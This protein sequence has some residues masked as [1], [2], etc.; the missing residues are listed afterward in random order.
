[1]IRAI[2]L[3]VSSFVVSAAVIYWSNAAAAETLAKIDSAPMS[4]L[5]P[6]DRMNASSRLAT[7]STAVRV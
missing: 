2:V 6:D 4:D 7:R 3:F 5:P 1:M